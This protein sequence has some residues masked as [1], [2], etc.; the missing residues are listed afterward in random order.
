MAWV[1]ITE[2][3]LTTA[4]SECTV[5]DTDSWLYIEFLPTV[6]SH[7]LLPPFPETTSLQH[8]KKVFLCLPFS[9]EEKT[10]LVNYHRNISQCLGFSQRA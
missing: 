8:G 2:L 4:C 10:E 9:G 5:G 1:Q 3:F 6:V 7:Y